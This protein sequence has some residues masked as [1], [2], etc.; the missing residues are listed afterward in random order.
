[1]VNARF[2]VRGGDAVNDGW[3]LAG[4]DLSRLMSS[5]A[6]AIMEGQESVAGVHVG[7]DP[8][9]PNVTAFINSS[10]PVVPLST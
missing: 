3:L 1:M 4:G 6:Q 2:G 8:A 10:S 5:A 9:S 7:T